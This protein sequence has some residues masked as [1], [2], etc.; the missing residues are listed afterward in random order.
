M[1]MLTSALT[2]AALAAPTNGAASVA[3]IE[4]VV[5]TGEHPPGAPEGAL[6]C[7]IDYGVGF[8]DLGQVAFTGGLEIGPGGVTLES[9]GVVFGPDADGNLTMLA[10][11][12]EPAPGAAF[13]VLFGNYFRA[14][15]LNDDGLLIFLGHAGY[16]GIWGTNHSGSVGLLAGA[17]T[18]PP[19]APEGAIFY[20]LGGFPLFNDT[21]E[22]A[23]D[24]SLQ[25]GV[26]GVYSWNDTGIWGPDSLGNLS[27]IAQEGSQAPDAPP[28]ARFDAFRFPDLNDQGDLAFLGTLRA[29]FG[30]VT[31]ADD[32]GLWGPDGSG[33]L[34]LLV[35]EGDPAPGAPDGARFRDFFLYTVPDLNDAGEVAFLGLLEVGPGGVTEDDDLGI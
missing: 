29:G 35:R 2:I 15:R 24:G 12:G 32:A 6:L 3:T 33:A 5:L 10:R 9:A 30:G 20:S 16:F 22:L 31:V 1:R 28:G 25:P 34:G 18:Q 14:P 27:L 4:P 13:G 7:C 17:G 23:F 8:N 19:G 26:G 11:A 21:G